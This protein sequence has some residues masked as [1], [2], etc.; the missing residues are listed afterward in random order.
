[1]QILF[2][3]NEIESAI[4]KQVSQLCPGSEVSS[5][6]F[7]AGR[8]ATGM[9]AEVDVVLQGETPEPAEPTKPTPAPK[10]PK[11]VETKPAA[12]E[13]EED[14]EVGSPTEPT[15]EEVAA[16]DTAETDSA[17]AEHSAPAAANKKGLF[18]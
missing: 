3:Q 13:E 7:T 10:K 15:K 11:A 5:I 8:G 1:M 6:T 4:Q 18:G 16:N 9:T 12:K 17:T 2:R 14:A